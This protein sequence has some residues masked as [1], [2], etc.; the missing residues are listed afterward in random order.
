MAEFFDPAD[1]ERRKPS[2]PSSPFRRFRAEHGDSR[3]NLSLVLPFAGAD[4]IVLRRV[5]TKLRVELASQG[6]YKATLLLEVS[7]A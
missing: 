4:S 1:Q 3:Q 5:P 2:L 6:T 7:K